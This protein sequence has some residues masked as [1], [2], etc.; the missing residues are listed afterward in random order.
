MVEKFSREQAEELIEAVKGQKGTLDNFCTLYPELC[1]KVEGVA[2]QLE[3]A[4]KKEISEEQV[5]TIRDAWSSHLKDCPNCRGNLGLLTEDEAKAKF[6]VATAPEDKP[7]EPEVVPAPKPKRKVFDKLPA[8]PFDLDTHG[9]TFDVTEDNKHVI[10]EIS[11]ADGDNFIQEY[12]EAGAGSIIEDA[13]KGCRLVCDD[14]DN[15]DSCRY[16]CGD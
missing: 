6:V 3:D 2:K 14:P 11:K 10:K 4:G 7:P 8:S 16:I 12:G 15:P 5:T 9:L 1:S 13:F